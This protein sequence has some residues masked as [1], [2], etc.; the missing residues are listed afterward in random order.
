MKVKINIEMCEARAA[1]VSSGRGSKAPLH[2]SGREP[3]NGDRDAL[4][5]DCGSLLARYVGGLIELKCRRC[6]RTVIVPIEGRK[7]D[8]E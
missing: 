3:S 1:M 6:K 7:A 2:P 4:R 5:C 8:D